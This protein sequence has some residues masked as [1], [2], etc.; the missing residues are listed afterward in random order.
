MK[1]KYCPNCDKAFTKSRLEKGR[2]IGC[3]KDNTVIVKVKMNFEYFLSYV[4]F[5]SGAL[6][7]FF[8]QY[9]NEIIRIILFIGFILVGALFAFSGVNKMKK[10]GREKGILI[11]QNDN[12]E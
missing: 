8:A 6:L 5:L 3:G 11:I 7:V 2:C 9:Y 10:T 12:E 1:F 4:A